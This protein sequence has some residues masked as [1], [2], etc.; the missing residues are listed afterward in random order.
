LFVER[1]VTEYKMGAS[2]IQ[3]DPA[4]ASVILSRPQLRLSGGGQ[5][6]GWPCGRK[7][8]G[9]NAT[10]CPAFPAAPTDNTTAEVS[11]RSRSGG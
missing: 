4:G 2:A 7:R 8:A 1:G 11:E 5:P 3:I 9:V 10:T 6:R